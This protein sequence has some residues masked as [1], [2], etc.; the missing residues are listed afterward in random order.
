MSLPIGRNAMQRLFAWTP[1][2]SWYKELR[3]IRTKIVEA[4]RDRSEVTG[5]GLFEQG[6]TMAAGAW[7]FDFVGLSCMLKGR[8]MAVIAAGVDTDIL[9]AGGSVAQPIYSDGSDA[10]LISLGAAETAYF[11]LIVCNSKGDGS[12]DEADNGNPVLLAVISGTATDYETQ[13]EH[14]TSTEIQTALE[15]ALTVHS[16]V[17]GW[18]HLAQCVITEDGAGGADVV[19]TANRNNVV[20]E[21]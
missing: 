4:F 11:T 14:L 1:R 6:A 8:M 18:A 15:A 7:K 9:I 16:G 19:I 13:T 3:L 10:S 21:A 5:G 20:S 17:T 12:A 2:L